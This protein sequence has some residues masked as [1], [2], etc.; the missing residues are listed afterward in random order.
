MRLGLGTAPPCGLSAF[1]PFGLLGWRLVLGSGARRSWVGL[2]GKSNLS[3][4]LSE[5]KEE[6]ELRSDMRAWSTVCLRLSE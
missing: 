4:F 5:E 2:G 3:L 6:K 1:R